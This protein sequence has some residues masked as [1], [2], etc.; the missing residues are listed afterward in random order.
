MDRNPHT[1]VEKTLQLKKLAVKIE[2]ELQICGR[3]ESYV[4][5]AVI[6]LMHF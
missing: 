2:K 3:P 4:N 6:F 1:I 5:S